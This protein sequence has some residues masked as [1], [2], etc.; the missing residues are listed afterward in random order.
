MRPTHFTFTG[1]D[2]DTDLGELA[3]ISKLHDCEWGVLFSKNRQGIDPRYPS[4]ARIDEITANQTLV[5]AAHL[6]GKVA[7]QVMETGTTDLDLSRFSRVQ[8]NHNDPNPRI[9]AEFS[10]RLGKP[11]IAQWRDPVAFPEATFEGVFWLYDLSGGRGVEVD[12]FPTNTSAHEVG[13]AGG[14]KPETI[15]SLLNKVKE[16][17]PA[18]FWLDMESGV[19][20]ENVFDLKKVQDVLDGINAE[21]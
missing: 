17:S 9:L 8:V 4:L 12:E 14:F 18:G 1:V 6:C 16:L 7:Q 10:Q 19:R 15:S 21:H 3:K 5:Y 13:Y 2:A 20:T 11:V